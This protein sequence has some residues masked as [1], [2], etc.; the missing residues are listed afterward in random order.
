MPNFFVV[1]T[2]IGNLADI[3]SRALE[4]LRSVDFIVCEDT[5]VTVKIL[6]FYSIHKPLISYFAHSRFSRVDL[7]IKLLKENKSGALV[8][9]AGTPGISDPGG[10]LIQ[11]ILK[12]IPE[13]KITPIPGPCAAI[14]ALSI[15]GFPAD[16]FS[17]LGFPPHKKGRQKFF[18]N[19]LS[20]KETVVFY[21]S[22]YRICK[23]LEE[24][25]KL[26]KERGEKR[27]IIV[28]RE[29]T[30]Q[31]ESIY[32]GNSDDILEKIKKDPIKGEYVVVLA[33]S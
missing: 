18:E 33:A 19:I 20:R 15:S 26:L 10:K 5:R 8:T 11:E 25:R 7:I 21:E 6:N 30:K 22:P 27:S 9:D 1:A 16:K 31:F 13:I 29:L 17:F 23:T 32:R 24:L 14:A 4:I 2:P 3:S 28:C 12:E